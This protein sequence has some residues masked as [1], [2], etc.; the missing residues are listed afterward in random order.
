MSEDYSSFRSGRE[1]RAGVLMWQVC[2]PVLIV[3]GT[4]GNII[5]IIVLSKPRFNRSASTVFLLALAAGD[6]SM[7]YIGLLRQWVKYAFDFDIR[8]A[9]EAVCKMHWWLMYVIADWTVWTLTAI[10][11]ERLIATLWPYKSK[12][13][14]SKRLA[15]AAVGGIVLSALL[16]NC[17]LLYGF[18]DVEI[19]EGNSTITLSC[20]PVNDSYARFFGK[21]WTWI[22]LCKFSLVPFA[23]LSAGNLCIIYKL[24]QSRRKVG[25]GIRPANQ[26][27][28]RDK[29]SNM[30]VVLV[31]LNFMFIIFTLPVSVY[32]IGEPYW[33]PSDVPRA[34]QLQ[35]PWW[36]VVNLAMYT[37]NSCNFVLYCL[38]GSR[39]REEVKRL[40]RIWRSRVQP[41]RVLAT[42]ANRTANVSGTI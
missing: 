28:P 3:L 24:L 29:T 15:Q 9:S 12:R 34:V 23:I 32:F 22:D 11:V 31:C 21:I 39:F 13:I 42:S 37:N 33:I 5:T 18:G 1:L 6:L 17:N 4:I 25:N 2:S 14:C 40:F 26:D 30:S 38:T 8:H 16:V 36:A 7:L 19:I 27:A 20:I 35:D 41:D 10:T